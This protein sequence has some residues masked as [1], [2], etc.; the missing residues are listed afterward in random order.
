M[1]PHEPRTISSTGKLT[2]F[3]KK[4]KPKEA[5]D[6]TNCLSCPIERK[7]NYS[8]VRLYKE[9][10]LDKGIT[11]WPL[12]IVCPDIEDTFK[13]AGSD[14]AEK[15]LMTALAEDYDRS[16]TS[17]EKIKSRS[18]YGRCVGIGQ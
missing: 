11:D 12:H 2:Q 7:C 10:Q 15:L 16:S 3:I 13:T 6:A 8:S 14:A 4:R 9:R 5:G 1:P 18:W 17:D